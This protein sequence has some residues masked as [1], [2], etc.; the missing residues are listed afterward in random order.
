MRG[1]NETACVTQSMISFESMYAL[2]LYIFEECSRKKTTRSAGIVSKI[3]VLAV[4]ML[5]TAKMM[6]APN[7]V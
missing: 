2:T 1:P 7:A 3:S 4:T 5:I 6:M